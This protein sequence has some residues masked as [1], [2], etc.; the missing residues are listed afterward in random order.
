MQTTDNKE[1]ER[2]L[3]EVGRYIGL[4]FRCTKINAP[5]CR[6]NYEKCSI[7]CSKIWNLVQ[8]NWNLVGRQPLGGGEGEEVNQ[9]F[10][11]KIFLRLYFGS[12]KL[13]ETWFRMCLQP[14]CLNS[15]FNTNFG[16]LNSKVLY[17]G[18]YQKKE[19][20]SV[21]DILKEDQTS[22]WFL[23]FGGCRVA[24]PQLL[25]LLKTCAP[26]PLWWTLIENSKS[27]MPWPVTG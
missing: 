16:F 6:L 23:F 12:S 26:S 4:R 24:L 22:V 11:K 1:G 7:I 19:S 27:L 25:Q 15:I 2:R 5:V 17:K 13:T 20:F 21:T 3:T 9:R 14:I 8:N 18:N 10:K